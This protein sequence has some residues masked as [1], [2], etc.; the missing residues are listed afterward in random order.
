[1][2]LL[3]AAVTIALVALGKIDWSWLPY[4]DEFFFITVITQPITTPITRYSVSGR[5]ENQ[6]TL[7]ETIYPNGTK[8]ST[9]CWFGGG[10]SG[11]SGRRTITQTTIVSVNNPAPIVQVIQ[12]AAVAGGK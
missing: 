4:I 11:N 7:N 12:P 2:K 6:V 3:I 10:G 1:M 5:G 9:R 8:I